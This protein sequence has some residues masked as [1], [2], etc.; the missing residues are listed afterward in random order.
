M[1]FSPSEKYI[2]V[3]QTSK[4][5]VDTPLPGSVIFCESDWNFYPY[6]C[7]WCIPHFQNKGRDAVTR[8]RYLHTK[9][10]LGTKK[11]VTE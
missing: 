6:I 5:R 8:I 4:T 9:N 1:N 10:N 3:S 11:Y 2:C 7:V